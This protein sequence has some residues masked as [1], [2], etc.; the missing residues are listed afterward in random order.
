RSGAAPATNTAKRR[1]SAPSR[2]SY[3]RWG[4]PGTPW[5]PKPG[6]GVCGAS[7]TADVWRPPEGRGSRACDKAIR[8][9]FSCAGQAGE[10]EQREMN[11]LP[12]FLHVKG[13]RAAVIG[14]GV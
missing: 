14:G 1:W 8:P 7:G 4:S 9:S 10:V 3:T 12:I 2:S 11:H 5:K 6:R 13:K